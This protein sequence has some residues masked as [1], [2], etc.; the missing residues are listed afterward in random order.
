M[1]IGLTINQ[2][3]YKLKKLLQSG[4]AIIFIPP[5]AVVFFVCTSKGLKIVLSWNFAYC[6]KKYFFRMLI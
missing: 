1:A 2:A 4:A 6:V 5:H 3:N